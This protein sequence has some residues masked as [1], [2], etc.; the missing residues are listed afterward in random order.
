MAKR[1]RR[2]PQGRMSLRR[3]SDIDAPRRTFLVFC[4]GERTEPDYLKALKQEP[5][6]RDGA[7]VEIRIADDPRGAVPYTLVSAAASSKSRSFEEADE[8]DEVWC[9]FDVEWPINHPRLDEA[10]SL[11]EESG[12]QLAISN[13]CFEL[14]LALHF[15]DRR[16][17]LKTDEAVS[18]RHRRDGTADTDKSVDGSIYMPRRNA[19]TRRA[20]YLSNMHEGNGTRFPNDNPSSGMFLFLDAIR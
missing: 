9:L 1:S 4:E 7:S 13:P 12:V 16:K 17:R 5:E 3:E 19:A 10:I 15:K 11:A 20:R 6:V 18:L 2:P 8:I 14:W